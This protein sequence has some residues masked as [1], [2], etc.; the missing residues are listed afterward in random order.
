[1]SSEA[2]SLVRPT[3][4]RVWSFFL[5]EEQMKP[6]TLLGEVCSAR[7]FWQRFE[8][9]KVS[10]LSSGSC[11][12]IC[13]KGMRPKASDPA[14]SEGGQLRI[15]NQKMPDPRQDYKLWVDI[16]TAI[17][18][19]HFENFTSLCG[20]SF[21]KQERGHNTV[22]VWLS[23]RLLS[24]VQSI[25][26]ELLEIVSRA[27]QYKISFHDNKNTP[28]PSK[29]AEVSSHRRTN[30]EQLPLPK[31]E[32]KSRPASVVES[33]VAPLVGI[34]TSSVVVSTDKDTTEKKKKAPPPALS[35]DCVPTAELNT[36]GALAPAGALFNSYSLLPLCGS[37]RER[38]RRAQPRSLSQ[39]QSKDFVARTTY[40]LRRSNSQYDMWRSKATRLTSSVFMGEE[41]GVV[42]SGSK[43]PTPHKAQMCAPVAEFKFE[44]P[45][46]SVVSQ[47]KEQSSF[48]EGSMW[49]DAPWTP[50]CL[51]AG[52]P[53]PPHISM[54]YKPREI[55][56]PF[57][58]SSP[59]AA[60]QGVATQEASV[61]LKTAPQPVV[62][63]QPS[64]SLPRSEPLTT[65]KKVVTD[66][67]VQTP[68]PP[69]AAT[70]ISLIDSAQPSSILR[71]D[72]VAYYHTDLG[73]MK[74]LRKLFSQGP[75]VNIEG[76]TNSYPFVQF[77]WWFPAG[78]NR[79][80]R[81][82][83][84]FVPDFLPKEVEGALWVG[85]SVPDG[86]V[87]SVDELCELFV[88]RGRE[89]SIDEYKKLRKD[90][91]QDK[92]NCRAASDPSSGVPPFEDGTS[93]F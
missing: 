91:L 31:E 16:T 67:Y 87:S 75:P 42:G 50:S 78:L 76:A 81:R 90:L 32:E 63:I 46:N 71:S 2:R 86:P 13:L 68:T 51:A 64:Q 38:A 17:V 49:A 84:Q 26:D 30:S 29:V 7:D 92:V 83:I 72:T 12:S 59:S 47:T 54:I 3:L 25:H 24:T 69:P 35:P 33:P 19:E 93:L 34:S 37:R 77:G 27:E 57:P 11:L 88:L 40:T 58:E 14:M 56:G 85:T 8:Q 22:I 5:E 44:T 20:V 41:M 15:Q 73:G 79:K 45:L 61:G 80:T 43:R 48:R 70:L 55:P 89:P 39:G 82:R 18:A 4:N 60:T 23:T 1:M 65:L 53:T 74:A 10:S 36:R 52:Q 9:H 21:H 6:V 62:Q 28:S 66:P